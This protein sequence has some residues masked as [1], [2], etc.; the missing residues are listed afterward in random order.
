MGEEKAQIT[1]TDKLAIRARNTLTMPISNTGSY[2]ISS[3]ARINA[4]DVTVI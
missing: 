3:A 1:L 4:T 2:Q